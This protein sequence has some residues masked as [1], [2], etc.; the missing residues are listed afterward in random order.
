LLKVYS[1]YQAYVEFFKA[2]LKLRNFQYEE[3]LEEYVFAPSA[4]FIAG[5]KTQPEMLSRFFDNLFHP[6]IHVGFGIEFNIP[7]IFAEGEFIRSI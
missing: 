5:A 3:L 2:E 7:G 1:F 4:N 6:M